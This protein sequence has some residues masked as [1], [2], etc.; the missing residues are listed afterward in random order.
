MKP[1]KLFVWQDYAYTVRTVYACRK[2][3]LHRAR[4]A[5]MVRTLLTYDANSHLRSANKEKEEENSIFGGRKSL[6]TFE[7]L[8][9]K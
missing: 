6:S 1:P 5:S 9:S 8:L 7:I 2:T 3:P 4:K